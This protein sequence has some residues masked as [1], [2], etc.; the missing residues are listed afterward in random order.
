[1]KPVT[2]ND[3]ARALG[4]SQT[5]VALVVGRNNNHRGRAKLAD[6]TVQRI[7][8]KARE[9]G[10]RPNRHAQVMR[11]GRSAQIGIIYR[12][13][14]L[15]VASERTYHITH[16]LAACGYDPVLYDECCHRQGL[17]G[18]IEAMLDAKVSGMILCYGGREAGDDQLLNGVTTPL[19]GLSATSV[20]EHRLI[21]CDMRDGMLQ[22]FRHLVA[23][24][25]R[26][27]ASVVPGHVPSSFGSWLWQQQ[28]QAEGIR[29]G[30]LECGGDFSLLDI[31]RYA[32]WAAKVGRS[33]ENVTA[34]A[35]CTTREIDNTETHWQ[36][37]Y[38]G[39]SV[40]RTLLD[41]GA[42]LPDA[43]ICPNDDWAVGLACELMRHGV[44]VPTEV[45][46]TGFNDS[47][48]CDVFTVPLTSIRQATQAMCQ[49]AVDL[50]T[51]E[52]NGEPSRGET[53]D[54]VGQLIPRD[55]SRFGV[56]G[57][58]LAGPAAAPHLHA[59]SPSP[60]QA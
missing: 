27:I 14:Q 26:R 59:F 5:T 15:Q 48:I 30:T 51:R 40:A 18:G 29:Q 33:G 8:E 42:P 35:L 25:C 58:E 54:L 56:P 7:Q 44:K 21:R 43:I 52:I 41:S 11:K 12:S 4:L 6:E 49:L 31:G 60:P 19:I 53:Y 45:A 13:S 55:S 36:P 57:D 2:Q 16:A 47:G 1:M 38:P 23:Q 20:G 9:L 32:E 37:Y 46:V 10:Y 3:I 39:L 28:M 34:T 17:E 22:T 24:G 50:L